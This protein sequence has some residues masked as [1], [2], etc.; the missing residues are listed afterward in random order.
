[1]PDRRRWSGTACARTPGTGWRRSGCRRR[2]REQF[3]ADFRH[4]AR[5]TSSRRAMGEGT[6]RDPRAAAHRQLGRRRGAGWSRTAG[7]WSRS[8][9]GS[10]RR[11]VFEQ[12]LRVPRDA[13]HGGHP[14]HRRP[15][16]AAGRARR[17]G[18]S[19]G[20][21]WRCSADR[22]L[23]RRGDRGAVLRRTH[24]D[25]GRAGA[26]RP[27]HRR[28]AVRGRPVVHDAGPVRRRAAAG[29]SCPRRTTGA[30]DVR[31]K[32][33]HPAAGRR[34]R[35]RHRRAPAGLAHAAEAVAVEGMRRCGSGS[36]RRTRSTCPAACRTTSST[37]PRR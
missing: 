14:A 17:E 12:F 20:T 2:S 25:A 11:R 9:S 33:D 36:S 4:A 7:R 5:S 26:A 3:L 1:M 13:R 16:A 19:R 10:S 37:W 15:A 24:P 21:R 30:L 32:I 31:V 27:A 29:S 35:G 28:A 23:S 8:P 34:V 22:D 6:G 18:H